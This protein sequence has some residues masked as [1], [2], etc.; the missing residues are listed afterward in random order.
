MTFDAGKLKLHAARLTA[1]LAAWTLAG[2]ILATQAWLARDVHGQSIAWIQTLTMWLAWGCLWALLTPLALALVDRFPLTRG[3]FPLTRGR[4]KANVALHIA[5]AF[6]F[7]LLDLALFAT[8]APLVGAKSAGLTWLDSFQRLFA[9]SFLL[10]VPV[11]WLII[12]AGAAL[13]VV[14]DASERERRALRLEAQLAEARLLVLRAQLEPHFLFNALNTISVLMRENVDDA[15]RVLVL[16]SGLLR[17]ALD[18]STAG[19][20]ELRHEIAFAE[21]YLALEQIR[22]AD[23]L[24]YR[25]DVEP[26]L[27]DLRVPSLILQPL[28]ENAVRHGLRE[29]KADGS[30]EIAAERQ[31]DM[32][33]LTVRDNGKGMAANASA[34]VGL[35]NTRSRLALLY[36][37]RHSF[38]LLP[39]PGGGL[40]ARIGI[41]L[42]AGEVS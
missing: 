8:I 39:A 5:A 29:R 12:G 19:E 23:R 41:P 24:T 1:V 33:W 20:I 28:I 14:R 21:A 17:R 15:D 36:G 22:F 11:Y 7:A 3:R 13:R 10:H 18:T 40:L 32:L 2:A 38:D 25:F 9:T 30:I 16:L 34:G 6:A 26:Q 27:L 37:E 42:S 35:S 4:T 31:S